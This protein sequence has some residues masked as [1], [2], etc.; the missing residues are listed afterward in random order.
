VRRA[1]SSRAVKRATVLVGI[2]L[3]VWLT[4]PASAAACSGGPLL[5]G[6]PGNPKTYEEAAEVIFTGTAVRAESQ[7]PFYGGSSLDPLL[8]TFVVDSVE[9]GRVGDR[10]T[11]ATTHDGAACG[12]AFELGQRYRV[13][14]WGGDGVLAA[15]HLWVYSANGTQRVDPLAAPPP[16]EGTIA[17]LTPM[18]GSI[19]VLALPV[20]LVG[21]F[22]YFFWRYRPRPYA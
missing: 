12:Y 7:M 9:K 22:A 11:I 16:I 6:M 5:T 21:S 4:L 2:G 20:L 19:L 14:A 1:A 15:G 18:L 17:P 10:F 13:L 3:A 8:F